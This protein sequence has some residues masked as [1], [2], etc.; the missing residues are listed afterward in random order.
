M[1]QSAEQEQRVPTCPVGPSAPCLH[2]SHIGVV[3]GATDAIP[4]PRDTSP[5]SRTAGGEGG[6]RQKPC[7]IYAEFCFCFVGASL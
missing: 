7:Q 5:T 4:S 3:C 6:G 2:T 1:T